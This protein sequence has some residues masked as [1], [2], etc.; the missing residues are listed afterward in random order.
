MKIIPRLI[1]PLVLLATLACSNAQA[2]DRSLL[3]FEPGTRWV[4]INGAEFPPGGKGNFELKEA[5][6]GMPEGVLN[7]DFSLGGKYVGAE[8]RVD[9]PDGY[10]ELRIRAKAEQAL[11]LGLRLKDSTGQVHQWQLAYAD[12]GKW[13]TLRV[14]LGARAPQHFSGAND[15]VLHYPVKSLQILV[16]NRQIEM[17]SGLSIADLKLL[18]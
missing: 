13:Q 7:Y 5:E 18:K 15:A 8:T 14:K 12:A 17:P 10:S 11:T 16:N 2:Q 1:T 4:F 9:L 6:N 3:V